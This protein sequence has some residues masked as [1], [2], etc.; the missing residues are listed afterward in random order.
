VGSVGGWR[1]AE[2]DKPSV[3]S[4]TINGPDLVGFVG[5]ET[6]ESSC[7]MVFGAVIYGRSGGDLERAGP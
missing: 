2:V 7:R 6:S 4:V 3:G 1:V 5:L